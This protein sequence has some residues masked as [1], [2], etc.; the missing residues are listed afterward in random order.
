MDLLPDIFL[1]RDARE[2][3]TWRYPTPYDI[4]NEPDWDEVVRLGWDLADT[5]ARRKEFLALRAAGALTGFLH[6]KRQADCVMLGVGLRPDLCGRGLGA[7]AMELACAEAAKRHSGV[8]LRLEVR[9]FNNRARKCY[10]QAGFRT[11]DRYVRQ[12]PLGHA[13]FFLMEQTE[14]GKRGS[15]GTD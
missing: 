9:T 6:L 1:E 15:R 10:E 13:E 2:V 12:T 3:C 8:P 7:K 14:R 5:R 4:Y 11:V